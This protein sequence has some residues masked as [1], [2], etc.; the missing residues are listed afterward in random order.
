[1]D[2]TEAL[3]RMVALSGKSNR[4][5]SRDLGRA[6]SFVSATLARGARPR[7]DTYARMAEVCG[8]E[9]V[10]RSKEDV[11]SLTP[12]VELEYLPADDRP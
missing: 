2:P 4:E 5:I 7:I 12:Q 3:K 6:E 11:I 9:L 10:L 8:Y 1:M